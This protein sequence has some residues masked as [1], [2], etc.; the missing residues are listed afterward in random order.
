MFKRTALDGLK[1]LLIPILF[2]T[3]TLV[4]AIYGLN[5]AERSSNAESLRT[6]EESIQRS[7]I[8]SFAI[9][10]RYPPSLE[11]IVDN[12]G[13]RI[14]ESRFVVFYEIFA[15]NVM[16]VVVIIDLHEGF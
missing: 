13:I 1:S 16:P 6:L 14:D 10:G 4:I 3:V 12:F 15:S 7:I 5:Q 2:M 9:D 11:Y 8:T